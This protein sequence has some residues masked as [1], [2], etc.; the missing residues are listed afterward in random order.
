[1][2]LVQTADMER[3]ILSNKFVEELRGAPEVQLSTREAM[4]ER[5]LGRYTSLDVVRQ[6]HLQNDVCRVQ[7]SQNLG[8]FFIFQS[9]SLF[10]LRGAHRTQANMINSPFNGRN[11][12]RSRIQSSHRIARVPE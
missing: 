4:C 12:G 11:V 7:L 2:Y 8:A 3:V 10:L 5:H 6:S 1:M 9:L